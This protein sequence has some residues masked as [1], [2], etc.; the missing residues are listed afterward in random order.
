MGT[1]WGGKGRVAI[2]PLPNC[3]QCPVGFW[4]ISSENQASWRD[5]LY[6]SFLNPKSGLHPSLGWNVGVWNV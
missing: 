3:G 2:I 5:P 1:W 4:T 6:P